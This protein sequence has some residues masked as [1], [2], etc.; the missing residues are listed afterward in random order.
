M[1][2]GIDSAKDKGRKLFPIH[3]V[4]VASTFG[5]KFLRWFV[6]SG[7]SA[8]ESSGLLRIV[9]FGSF[10]D[11][12]GLTHLAQIGYLSFAQINDAV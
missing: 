9:L 5:D 12:N 7:S 11:F 10:C 4:E 1:L 8:S 3:K 6:L 2:S